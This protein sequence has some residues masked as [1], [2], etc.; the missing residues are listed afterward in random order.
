MNAI[1]ES[2]KIVEKIKANNPKTMELLG[3]KSSVVES[4]WEKDAI[5]KLMKR[6]KE[7]FSEKEVLK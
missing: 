5:R 7:R 1:E 2:M 6:N 3:E 4:Y